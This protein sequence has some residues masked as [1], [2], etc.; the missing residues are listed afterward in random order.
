MKKPNKIYY[1]KFTKLALQNFQI[2]GQTAPNI[3]QKAL[4]IVKLAAAKTNTELGL[5]TRTQGKLIEKASLEFINGDFSDQFIL[6]IFQAGAGTSYNMNANEIIANRAGEEIHPNDHVNIAQ[7][8]N[9]VIPTATRIAVLLSL[10]ALLDAIKKLEKDLGKKV[11]KYAKTTKVGRTHLQDA[12]PIT[13]GQEFDSY[14]EAIRKSREFIERQSEEL[15]IINLGGTAVGTGINTDPKY[16]KLVLKNLSQITKIKFKSTKNL[17]EINNNMNEFMNF[18]ATL[19]SLTTNLLNF[20]GDL[21]LMNMGPKAGIS[22]I[23]LP[24]SQPGSSIM[25]GKI[26]PSIVEC[27]EMVCLQVCG[28]D[29]TIEMAAQKSQFELNI[30]CPLIMHNLLE[31]MNI[32]TNGI[33]TFVDKSLKE[34]TVKEDHV[35]KMLEESLAL[36]TS[37]SPYIGYSETAKVVKS[38][39]RK[40]IP[41]REEVKERKL[42]SES[43][44]NK[45]LSSKRTTRPSKKL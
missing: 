15:K 27:M 16:H 13:F 29:R 8:T 17:T 6:D 28:N 31:S 18:S 36:A 14:K 4:G 41:L 40:N 26:N 34:T 2:S 43:K 37:L 12:V 25:P 23:N 35:Q 19:R 1:G 21:K 7:S 22:E 20:S 33:D 44:L 5:L 38:A 32:L 10:P 11:K 39:L 42:L 45:I 9:D 24:E 3:F 30:F